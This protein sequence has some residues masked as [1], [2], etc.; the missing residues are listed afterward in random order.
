MKSLSIIRIWHFAEQLK[1]EMNIIKIYNIKVSRFS[2]FCVDHKGIS[3]ALAVLECFTKV[4]GK[5]SDGA[6][7]CRWLNQ[8]Y[9][10]KYWWNYKK[11]IYK[12]RSLANVLNGWSQTKKF[13]LLKGA[14]TDSCDL[15]SHQQIFQELRKFLDF[16]LT[17]AAS[18]L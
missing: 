2:V 14:P 9:T 12:Y 5:N 10:S 3:V 17:P 16:S 6:L 13:K 1:V 15:L 4:I 8:R 7:F 18:L 11:S